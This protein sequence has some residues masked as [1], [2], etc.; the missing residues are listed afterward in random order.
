MNFIILL[1][2][3]YKSVGL[4][5]VYAVKYIRD[6]PT[7]RVKKLSG[8]FFFLCFSVRGSDIRNRYI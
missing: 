7:I 2:L 3:F 4:L 5:L 6:Q 1:D 8:S